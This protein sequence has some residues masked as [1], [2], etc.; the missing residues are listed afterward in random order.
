MD[1]SRDRIALTSEELRILADLEHRDSNV[2]PKLELS[3]T[4]GSHS[5]WL[6]SR[7]FRDT[8]WILLFWLGIALM[9][10][11]FTTWPIVAAIAVIVQAIGLKRLLARWCPAS[12]SPVGRTTEAA[13]PTVICS[14]AGLQVGGGWRVAVASESCPGASNRRFPVAIS[15][16]RRVDSQRTVRSGVRI[17]DWSQQDPASPVDRPL[18]YEASCLLTNALPAGEMA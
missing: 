5:A 14:P 1:G 4:V 2:D 3:L 12:G 9:L 10:A 13:G 17:I 15:T 6:H 11:T 8:A 16:H 18:E 7:R